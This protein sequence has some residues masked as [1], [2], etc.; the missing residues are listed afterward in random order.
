MTTSIKLQNE[1]AVH[2]EHDTQSKAKCAYKPF[3]QEF[4]T[5]RN[6]IN[7]SSLIFKFDLTKKI[8]VFDNL[9]L[10]FSEY[11]KNRIVIRR[12]NV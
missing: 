8:K 9:F 10:Q 1:E 4:K 6:E 3:H 7:H 11:I 2:P 5:K 12:R